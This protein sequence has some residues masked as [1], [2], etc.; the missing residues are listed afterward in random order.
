MKRPRII[1]IICYLGFAAL[2]FSFLAVFSPWVKKLGDF[3]PV[4]YGLIVA[5]GF[6]SFVGLWYMKKWG[7]ELFIGIFFVKTVFLILINDLGPGTI[8][9]IASSLL[10][11]IP[12][13]IFYP[14]M[15]ANL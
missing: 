8:F 10:Y 9:S 13:V 3:I 15:D 2:A 7:V 1:S 4:I 5:G 14:K 6:M 11:I 12:L